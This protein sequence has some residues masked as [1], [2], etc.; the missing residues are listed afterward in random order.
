MINPIKSLIKKYGEK[1]I[2]SKFL[3]I[4]NGLLEPVKCKKNKWIKVNKIIM[5]GKIKWIEKN[6]VNVAFLIENPPQIQITIDSPK[7]GIADKRFVITVAPQKDIC[8]QGNTYPT[9]AVII[10][11]N[12]KNTPIIHVILKLKEFI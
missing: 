4:P 5:K 10:V 9:K 2:L 3:L 7:Y 1:V 11:N 6:R 8:P 12:N